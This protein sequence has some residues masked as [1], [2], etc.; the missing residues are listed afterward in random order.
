MEDPE[1]NYL[2]DILKSF[3]SH[4]LPTSSLIQ[5]DE[6]NLAYHLLPLRMSPDSSISAHSTSP[7]FVNTST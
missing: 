2:G 7:W 5:P 4:S 1:L 6:M 3:H